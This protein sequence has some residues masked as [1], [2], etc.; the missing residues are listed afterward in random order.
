MSDSVKDEV[1]N[2]DEPHKSER[3]HVVLRGVSESG[4]FA[5]RGD[6]TVRQLKRRLSE[7]LRAP[8]EHLVLTRSGRVLRESELV[9]HITEQKGSVSLC[10]I[11]SPDPSPAPTLSDPTSEPVRSELT[12]D[13]NPDPDQTHTPTSPLYLVEDLDSLGLENCRSSFFTALRSQME[14]QLQS[15]PEMM[16]RVPASPPVQNTLCTSSPQLARQLSLSN[17]QLQQ[18][19]K[20]NPEV[21]DML[22]NSEKQVLELIGEP[23]MTEE[24][25]QNE[26]R[27][28]ENVALVQGNHENT[29]SLEVLQTTDEKMQQ[30]HRKQSQESTFPLVTT[31]RESHQNPEGQS[32]PPLAS[33]YRDPHRELTA[34]PRAGSSFQSTLT[35]GMQSLLEGISARPGLMES[36]MSGP[37][38]NSL[39]NCLSQNPDFAAQ[40]LLSHPLF[41]GN[42]PLQEQMRQ[43]IPLFLQQMQ[44]PE[45]LSAMLNPRAMEALRQIQHGL[46]T[47]AVEAP[48][49]MPVAGLGTSGGSG[50]NS[51]SEHPSDP[52]QKNQSGC[53]AQKVPLTQ[54][55]QQQQQQFVHQMLKAL[56]NTGNEVRREEEEDFQEELQQL[57]SMGFRDKQAN[58][59][60]LISTGGDLCSALHLLSL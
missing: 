11:R 17:P 18:V 3:I 9:S 35:A 7:R 37:H 40:M 51:A 38:I 44:S 24:A 30:H 45:L 57:S 54:Q 15:D 33:D 28:L 43:Q 1:A 48:L 41:S 5:I 6:C 21:E 55:Q 31:S 19:L 25:M 29:A 46:Q 59:Q 13:P 60:A 34:T 42:V 47:L 39:L 50:P 58:L 12:A 56:A 22:N 4:A 20:A 8:A 2:A 14:S 36:L 26:G 32:S 10:S 16:H 52:D 27:S 49:L 23:E 53:S